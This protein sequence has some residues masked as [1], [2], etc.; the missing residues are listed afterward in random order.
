MKKLLYAAGTSFLRAFG[1]ALLTFGV[2]ILSAPDTKTAVALSISALLA[3]LA[4][5]LR[6]IQVFIPQLSFSSFLPQP[7]AAWADSFTRA[8]LATLVITLTGWLDA[9]DLAT[10]KAVAV[11][12]I[13][14]ALAAGVRALQGL[15]T[16][17]EE[18][19]PNTGLQ[20]QP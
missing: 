7:I 16:Q 14:G 8:F 20:E 1:A 6:A 3:S 15:A 17:G 12:A 18:P 19:A 2:G 5:G 9:P 10:W 4:M 13:V 11:A